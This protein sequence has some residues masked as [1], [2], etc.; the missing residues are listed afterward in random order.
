MSDTQTPLVD[1]LFDICCELAVQA[2]T[3]DGLRRMHQVLVVACGSQQGPSFG[4]LFSQIDWLCKHHGLRA[5]DKTAVQTA[6]R[7]SNQREPLSADEWRY[8]LRAVALFLSAL[9]AVDVPGRLLTLLPPIGRPVAKMARGNRRYTRCIVDHFDNT[10]I[11]ADTDHG[12]VAVDYGDTSHGRDLTYLAKILRPGMQLNLLDATDADRPADA[13]S[14]APQGG[15]AIPWLRPALIVVEPDFLVDV[16][17]LAACFTAYGHHPLLYTINRLKPRANTQAMLLGNFAGAALDAVIHQAQVSTADILQRSFR[18]QP[19]RFCACEGFSGQLFKADAERQVSN[20]REAVGQLGLGADALSGSGATPAERRHVGAASLLEPSFICER[21]GLQGRV[22]LMTADMRLLVE[23]KAGR[24]MKIERQ[25]HD[26]HGMQREDH[27]V[28]LLLYYGIL[29]YN[30]QKSDHQVDTRLLYSRYAAR[31]GLLAVNYY[32]MLFRE[33][34]KLRNQVVATEMLIAREGFGRIAPLLSSDVVYQG[35]TRDS[36]FLRYVEPQLGDLA[37]L[38]GSL[39]PLEHDYFCRMM[40]FVY[41]EQLCQK[42]GSGPSSLQH[43]GGCTADLWQM[44]LSEKL[45]TGNIFMALTVTQREKTASDGGYDLITLQFAKDATDAMPSNFRRGDMVYLYSYINEP[46]VRRS[47]LYKGTLLSIGTE[48][49]TVALNDGQQNPDVFALHSSRLWAVEHAASD[50]G[51]ASAIHGLCQ[52]A[53]ASPE[54]RSLLLGQRPPRHDLSRHLSRSYSPA[55][56]DIVL[57]QKQSLDYFLLVGP[58]GTGKTS[59]ALRFIVEEELAQPGG[60]TATSDCRRDAP[61][62]S[63]LLTAYTNR[64]V[65]EICGMLTDAGIPFLRIGY[66]SSCDARY[67]HRLLEHQPLTTVAAC[68]RMISATPVVVG[69]TSMLASQSYI[70]QIKHFSLC[71]VDEA[72]QILEPAIIGLLASDSIDR[73]VLVGDYKQLPAVVMQ[74]GEEASVSE[75]SLRAVCLTDCRQS[76]F[77]RLITW[78]HHERRTRFTGILRRQGR[79][80]PDV[81]QFPNSRFYQREQLLTVPLPHQE[82]ASALS[83]PAAPDD[84]LGQLLAT[85][86]VLFLPAAT[87]E[88]EAAVVVDVLRRLRSYY[89]DRFDSSHSVGVIVPYR[90]QIALIRHQLTPADA[91]LGDLSIDTVERYQGS[92]RDVI[93]YSFAV[94]RRFQLGFLTANTFVEDGLLIDRKLNVALTRARRQMIMVGNPLIL[95]HSPLFRQLISQYSALPLPP[96]SSASPSPHH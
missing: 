9:F 87:V 33:A 84:R 78:E 24:N 4:N 30:F 64:A 47:I 95:R 92:Q 63:V 77:E 73:F 71:V 1:E 16:S 46:D 27:Y 31:Q 68:R 34:I 32:R 56:D 3:A 79:M 82:E 55:Y 11:W 12:P 26:A 93:I 50:M 36:F 45:Q 96:D 43:S 28:Q 20:I 29:R 25:S 86:R 91:E 44:P 22:D 38:F 74:S 81:A 6:R 65:D 35:V 21:L 7:H 61:G 48:E 51:T 15:A 59:Q 85:H 90:S 14:A 83:Y 23:Q 5:A 2:C 42:L 70:F 8:D 66:A 89:A 72:S 53:S 62:A 49:L 52:F 39:T 57:R 13:A 88:E 80:H 69:T 58:P 40:T 94:S 10:T 60:G 18:E 75:P 76:L 67:H 54:R 19:L 41:R 37:K 17:S